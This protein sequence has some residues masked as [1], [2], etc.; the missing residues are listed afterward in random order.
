[1]CKLEKDAEYFS[2]EFQEEKLLW[3]IHIGGIIL[4][5]GLYGLHSSD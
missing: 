4:K 3:D 2:E 5:C 1:M